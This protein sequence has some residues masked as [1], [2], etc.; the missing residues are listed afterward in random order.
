MPLVI[1]TT[2]GK[3]IDLK[4]GAGDMRQWRPG[5]FIEA[6]EMS[7]MKISINADH[8]S[9]ISLMPD[10]FYAAQMAE[11]RRQREAARKKN[12][13]P[14]QEPRLVVPRGS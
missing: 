4:G 11:A 2:N 12:P 13:N 3:R 6:E 1:V 9:F 10:E 14:G 5:R 7:G 8:V